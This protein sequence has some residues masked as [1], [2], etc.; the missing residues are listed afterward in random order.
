MRLL[1]KKIGLAF[2]RDKNNIIMKIISFL[3]QKI[4]IFNQKTKKIDFA[5]IQAQL[6]LLSIRNRLIFFF[7]LLSI[8]PIALMGIIAYTTST[9]AITSKIS[10]YSIEGLNQTATNLDLK[11]SKYDDYARELI[12]SHNQ[13]ISQLGNEKNM[14]DRL[15]NQREFDSIFINSMGITDPGTGLMF[16]PAKDPENFYYSGFTNKEILSSTVLKDNQNFWGYY[17]KKL[18]CVKNIS[19]IQSGELG[20]LVIFIDG[21]GLNKQ[22]NPNFDSKAA[23]DHP[24][25]I[26][27]DK[28]MQVIASPISEDLGQDLSKLMNKPLKE[29]V[30]E[31][32][33]D[34]QGKMDGRF[35]GQDVMVTYSHVEK[36]DWYVLNIA[37]RS[38][39]YKESNQIGWW[40]LILG[41]LIAVVTIIISLLVALSITI[42]L[43]RILLG[44]SMGSG[45]ISAAATQLSESAQQLSQ[46]STMQASAIEETA[47]TIQE[48]ASMM[49]QNSLNTKQ[50]VQLSEQANGAA[51]KGGSEM[52][53]M[54]QSMQ[55]IKNSSDRIA[56]IIKIIDGIAFQTNILALN[57]AIEAARAGE[58]GLSFAVVAEEVRNL[59]QRSAQAAKDTTAII[60]ANLE[61][62]AKGVEIAEKVREAFTEITL[63]S[64]KV[65]ELLTEIFAASKEQ[66]NGAAQVTKA[67]SQIETV[68]G[69]NATNAEDNASAAQ[70]LNTQAT[71]MREFVFE[72][73]KLVHGKQVALKKEMEVFTEDK[74][75]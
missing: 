54:T 37:L 27:I 11:L 52:Q 66:A 23:S 17:Q 63:Q 56:K 25:S 60:E 51:N 47:S 31:F 38:Y 9:A 35:K 42:P 75:H 1:N 64:G 32:E 22:I 2:V 4:I 30:A 49:E 72:L 57:A 67:M 41:L 24:Y 71:R 7:L 59:S 3:K 21:E 46:G 18:L 20:R 48:T 6:N 62:S 53:A 44:L 50:A 13:W 65:N 69:K 34:S 36:K 70:K 16:I 39:L 45:Q 33:K 14:S 58:A 8:V 68:T 10:N 55:E 12:T 29:L 26:I 19:N 5:K 73:S 43:N 61:S 40:A 15:K 74:S 28:N